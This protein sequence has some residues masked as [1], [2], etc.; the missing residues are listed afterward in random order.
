M[1]DGI[2]RYALE[3]TVPLGK[4]NGSLEIEILGRT[5]T[6]FLTM[7]ADT[8][9]ITSG[10][11]SGNGI[12]FLGEMKILAETIPYVA[13]GTIFHDQIQLVFHTERGDYPATGRPALPDQ[14]R[15]PSI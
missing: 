8:Q 1:R 2:Y 13:E 12:S 7:F 6:G 10:I 14:R 15:A 11:C 4:R 3:M 9:R 5:V